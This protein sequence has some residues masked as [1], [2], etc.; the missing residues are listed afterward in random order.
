G[1][2]RDESFTPARR[3]SQLSRKSPACA[4][5]ASPAPSA[6]APLTF[7]GER[8]RPSS[9]RGHASGASI[10]QTHKNTQA[11]EATIPPTRPAQVFDGLTLGAILGPPIALPAK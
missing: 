6:T 3:L 11:T 7:C 8:F 5:I 2:R 10:A 4:T 1:M 9:K